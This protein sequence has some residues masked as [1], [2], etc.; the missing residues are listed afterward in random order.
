[1]KSLN[2][3][4]GC[5]SIC[6][7]YKYL[8]S[9]FTGL[10]NDSHIYSASCLATDPDP[11]ALAPIGFQ[12]TWTTLS[13]PYIS[14]HVAWKLPDRYNSQNVLFWLLRRPSHLA[15]HM[16]YTTIYGSSALCL[17]NHRPTTLQHSSCGSISISAGVVVGSSC[18]WIRHRLDQN[19]TPVRCGY[20]PASAIGSRLK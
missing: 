10:I 11:L 12:S 18:G 20:S 14:L 3:R 19:A 5:S 16:R 13:L 1:M 8:N 7:E 9:F 6:T 15:I 2:G 17:T 4:V